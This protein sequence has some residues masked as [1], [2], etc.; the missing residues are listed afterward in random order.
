LLAT[1]GLGQ[2]YRNTTNPEVATGTAVAMAYLAG[3][4]V[5]DM[6]FSIPSHGALFENARVF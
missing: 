5:S 4:E 2:I 1:G 6:E 3:A